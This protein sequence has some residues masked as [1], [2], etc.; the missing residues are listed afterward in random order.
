M[1]KL[2]ARLER[3]GLLTNQ[4]AGHV[5]GEP[6]AWHLTSTGRAVVDAIEPSRGSQGP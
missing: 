2:L 4:G 1:S 6:N 5:K 3:A